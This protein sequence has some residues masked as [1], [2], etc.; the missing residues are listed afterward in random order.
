MAEKHFFLVR[1]GETADNHNLIH[2]SFSVPL[3]ER[4]KQEANDVARALA[5]L[6]PDRIVTSDA[7]RAQQ[8]AAPLALATGLVPESTPLLREFHRGVLLEGAHHLSWSSIVGSLGLYFHAGDRA[9]HYGDGENAL[10]FRDRIEQI[11][12][13]LAAFPGERV[14]VVA[15]RGVINALRFRIMRGQDV[16]PRHFLRAAALG[17]IANGSITELS[18]DPGRAAPWQVLRANDTRHLHRA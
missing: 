9:W 2:Q 7:E 14:V 17:R 1:H 10:E 13:E 12:S 4:G 5:L 11:L 6:A 3:N 8:T 16:H 18:Y 15:H